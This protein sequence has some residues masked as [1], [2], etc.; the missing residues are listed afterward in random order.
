MVFSTLLFIFRFLPVTL[1][2]YYIV[3]AKMKNFVLF[4]AS[5]IFYS[6]GEVRFFPIMI[7]VI[8]L[9]YICGLL[10]ERWQER[11]RLRMLVLLVAIVGSLASLLVF[12]YANF[13]I[14][15]I[16]F[17]LGTSIKKI[18]AAATLPLGISFYTF[19]MMSYTIDVYH[20]KTKAE[21]NFIDFGAYVAMFPQLIAGPIVKYRDIAETLHKK[22]RKICLPQAED[23][24]AQFVMGLSR[25]VLLADS[26]SM[27]WR[28]IIG[29]YSNGVE[30]DAGIG[31]IHASTPLV[32]LG[33]IAYSLQLYFDFSG[34]SQMSI[35]IGKMLGFEFPENFDTPYMAKSIT[36]F[37]RK[38]HM[39]LSG[40]FREYI[41]IPLGGNRKGMFRQIINLFIVW[42][43]T[44]LWHG[45]DWNFVLWGL[46]Y[47]VLLLIEKVW[48]LPVL[49]KGKILPHIY[50]IILFVIGWALFVGN[51]AGVDLSVLLHKMFVWQGGV[52]ARY[53]LRNY[54]VILMVCIACCTYLPKRLWQTISRK[55]WIKTI[56][57][58]LL[59]FLCITYIVGTTN[60]PFLY[61]NF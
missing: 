6:W 21:R 18:A 33:I 22:D 9:N 42:S 55:T 19:Q 51:D 40:W 38:W 39:T 32:W 8:I 45:A 24:V 31:L 47:F 59:L 58:A 27:L 12:K 14:E 49:E 5:L 16:N 48:L 46:Y 56:T 23:G 2:L 60:S 3:P 11:E 7:G 4:I 54:A 41:Y 50:T 26:I 53:F 36:E 17:V 28:D 44:G 1:L 43:L 30:I 34:Y 35:G 61:F 20:D 13:A 25:K 15:T 52:S 57:I 29:T 10:V 37:W